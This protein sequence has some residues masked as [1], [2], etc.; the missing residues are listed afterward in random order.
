MMRITILFFS[1]I[2]T[3]YCFAEQDLETRGLAYEQKIR[4][5]LAEA[6]TN[7]NFQVMDQNSR[8]FDQMYTLDPKYY[9]DGE[10]PK[11]LEAH[12]DRILALRL[13]ILQ[14]LYEM[15]DWKY[16]LKNHPPFEMYSI[17]MPLPDPKMQA[18]LEQE[19]AESEK[20][21]KKHFREST[22]QDKYESSLRTVQ[23][24]LK[25]RKQ[26]AAR[27]GN[28]EKLKAFE[29]IIDKQITNTA[30][31]D[32]IYDQPKTIPENGSD[33]R[34]KKLHASEN[35]IV[36]SITPE[37]TDL[38]K[39]EAFAQIARLYRSDT[40]AN[41]IAKKSSYS[42]KALQCQNLPALI[43]C[44]MYLFFAEALR[45][46]SRQI[47]SAVSE[48]TERQLKSYLEGLALTLD[49]LKV[50]ERVPL[51][52]VERFDVPPGNPM[53]AE[54]EKRHA[55]QVAYAEYADEQNELL[56]FRDSFLQSIFLL[57]NPYAFESYDFNKRLLK[58]GYPEEKA[59]AVCA[60]LRDAAQKNIENKRKWLE[61]Q[62][63][64]KIQRE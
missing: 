33:I 17:A 44:E 61:P 37:A 5:L 21:R 9:I 28:Q 27:K 1:L 11:Y 10:F 34:L 42:E 6:R 36:T 49:H 58:L 55:E 52:G 29:E 26:D 57:S 43:R 63:P 48:L 38:Q 14:F 30:L 32:I 19:I 62:N 59:K 60:V 22:L 46:Q 16:D 18:K 50:T 8:L 47:P 54:F 25:S 56:T 15:R 2:L 51:R 39:A 40:N 20:N 41:S 23:M 13:D 7:D 24:R 35:K 4:A 3:S 12:P 64:Q 45:S 53:R 31:L